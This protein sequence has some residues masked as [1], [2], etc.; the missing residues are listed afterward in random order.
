M[1]T[2]TARYTREGNEWVVLYDEVELSTFG[3]SLPAARRH[4]RQALAVYLDTTVER[5]GGVAVVVDVIPDARVYP[6]AHAIDQ[7]RRAEEAAAEAAEATRAAVRQLRARGWSLADVADVLD[8]SPQAVSKL[9][10]TNR[11]AA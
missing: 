3:R 5:L 11:L 7:R 10:R 4:A 9:E 1:K 8:V 6:I 2:Y